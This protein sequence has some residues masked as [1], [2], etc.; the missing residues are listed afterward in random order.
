MSTRKPTTANRPQRKFRRRMLVYPSFQLGMVALNTAVL[1]AAFTAV[2]IQAARSFGELQTQGLAADLPPD[3][4][5]FSFLQ[6]QES[7]LTTYLLLGAMAGWLLSLVL[8]LAYSHRLAGPIVRLR[9]YLTHVAETGQRPPLE[10]R[11]DDFFQDLPFLVNEAFDRVERDKAPQNGM[12]PRPKL[13]SLPP[14]SSSDGD[15]GK[16]SA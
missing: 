14:G 13:V 2:G 1:L 4:S 15:P 8:T 5:Y 9:N 11:E 16:K 7:H 10:F 3:H 12:A 6:Y